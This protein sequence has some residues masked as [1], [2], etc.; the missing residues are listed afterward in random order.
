MTARIIPDLLPRRIATGDALPSHMVD[1]CLTMEPTS[2]R[3]V[4]DRL[5][6]QPI[7]LR[8]INQTTYDPLC[9]RPAAV[10]IE[11]KTA[12]SAEAG[13]NQLAIWT[14]AWLNRMK[15][16]LRPGRRHKWPPPPLLLLKVV[17]HDWLLLF[18][19]EEPDEARAGEELETP[20]RVPGTERDGAEDM[21]TDAAAVVGDDIVL[22][23][24]PEAQFGPA[25]LVIAGE[26]G[27]GDTRTLVGA[28]K[29]I[30]ALRR[31]ATWVDTDFRKWMEAKVLELPSE[32][33]T[34]EERGA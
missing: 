15:L 5:A 11:T 1:Y 30:K 29:V 31:I 20:R 6:D 9:F 12:H 21:G 3:D 26:V 18:S 13:R 33:G 32:L 2:L 10:A 8:T 7:H 25:K 24:P 19:W 22:T 14:R 4:I 23:S 34:R 16:L 27:I 28:Y 17:G